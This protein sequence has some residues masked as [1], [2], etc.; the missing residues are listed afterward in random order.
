MERGTRWLEKEV[1]YLDLG[2]SFLIRIRSRLIAKLGFNLV[3]WV[4]YVLQVAIF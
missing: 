2:D 1:H 3:I 4:G